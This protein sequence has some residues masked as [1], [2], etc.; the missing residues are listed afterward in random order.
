MITERS[1]VDWE[2][3]ARRRWTEED[4]RI[5]LTAW[6]RSGEAAYTFARAHGLNAQRLHWWSQRLAEWED[7]EVEAPG[8][9]EAE[10]KPM[11]TLLGAAVRVHTRSGVLVEV[12]PA[13]VDALWVAA[14]VRELD[15]PAR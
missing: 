2:A 4:A 14:L 9:V 15:E 8:L 1:N 13:Q 3:L 10:L 11:S 12:D 6:R 7:D 5:A